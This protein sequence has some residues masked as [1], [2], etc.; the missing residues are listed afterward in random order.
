MFIVNELEELKVS[1]ARHK[2]MVT[3]DEM[4]PELFKEFTLSSNDGKRVVVCDFQD[5]DGRTIISFRAT[6]KSYTDALN[7]LK[8]QVGYY[9]KFNENYYAGGED[10]KC[11]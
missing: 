7:H 8:R 6:G 4:I 9:D 3:I 5:N 11:V 2:I 10:Y 1:G